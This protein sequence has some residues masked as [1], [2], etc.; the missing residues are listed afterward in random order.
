MQ[1]ITVGLCA[2]ALLAACTTSEDVE[3]TNPFDRNQEPVEG[4][5][6]VDGGGD[7]GGDEP[8]EPVENDRT[9]PPGTPNPTPDSSITRYE[10][11]N[12]QGGGYARSIRY[13]NA[14]GEDQFEVDNIAFDGNNVYERGT[15]VSSIGGYA[16]YEAAPEVVND[17]TGE[18]V[19]NLTYRAVYG[20]SQTSQSEFAIVRSGSYTSYGFGGFVYQRNNFDVNGDPYDLNIP[21]TGAAI[22]RGD[23]GGVRIFDGRRGL[24]YVQG[25]AELRADFEDFN[26]GQ[27]GVLLY[28]RDCRL[29]DINGNDITSDYLTA[30]ATQNPDGDIGATLPDLVPQVSPDIADGRGI[31]LEL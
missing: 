28:V 24:E 7:T 8:T 25:E 14:N 18:R 27:A 26:D 9:L 2:L 19:E 17:E 11:I 29:F 16:V 31:A 3:G 23:Y 13:S 30:L 10:E 15:A 6:G 12:D 20:L 5:E 21:E 1:K 4:E 22:Y